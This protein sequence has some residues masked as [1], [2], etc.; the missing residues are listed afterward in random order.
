[1][2]VAELVKALLRLPDQGAPVCLAP[3]AGDAEAWRRDDQEVCGTSRWHGPHLTADGR[4]LVD[5]PYIRL[6]AD[7]R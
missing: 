6:D 7:L 2:T 5:G 4:A 3:L 1:V